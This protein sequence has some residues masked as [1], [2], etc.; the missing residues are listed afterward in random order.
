MQSDEFPPEVVEAVGT[1]AER[2]YLDGM[3]M[4]GREFALSILRTLAALG[5]RRVGAGEC[6]VP[7][8]MTPRMVEVGQMLSPS[9]SLTECYELTREFWGEVLAAS[10]APENRT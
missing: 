2:A 3:N 4:G 5:Y 10:P 8:E 6:V 7:R 1:L 9:M